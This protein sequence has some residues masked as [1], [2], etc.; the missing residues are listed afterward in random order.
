LARLV[1]W[2]DNPSLRTADTPLWREFVEHLRKY[3]QLYPIIVVALSDGRYMIVDGHRRYRALMQIGHESAWVL[4]S[5]LTFKEAMAAYGHAEQLKLRWE[6]RQLGELIRRLG[7]ETVR[8]MLRPF[9][10]RILDRAFDHIADPEPVLLALD[11]WGP[12]A[13]G[14]ALRFV[15]DR[16]PLDRV[17]AAML[18]R[19]EIR[20][21][22]DRLK[23]M[24]RAARRRAGQALLSEW[25][26]ATRVQRAS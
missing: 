25:E 21:L 11:H 10:R 24:S 22:E 2:N 23:G 6:G 3:G 20:D 18:G 17:L 19:G 4:V 16:W 7:Y 14:V 5:P 8:P 9:Y 12:R 26:G 15:D 1:P 13:L